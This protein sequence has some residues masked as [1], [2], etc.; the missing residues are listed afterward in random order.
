MTTYTEEENDIDARLAALDQKMMVHSLRNI[1]LESLEDDNE[2]MEGS[3][4]ECLPQYTHLNNKGKQD[5]FGEWMDSIE[6]LDAF[7]T[8]KRTN[9]EIDDKAIDYMD[10]DPTVL[11]LKQEGIYWEPLTIVEATTELKN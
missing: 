11:M 8:N 1:T 5:L 10:E 6:H 4:L 7:V 2:K 9:I 3:E